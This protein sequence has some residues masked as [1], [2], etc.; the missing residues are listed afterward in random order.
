M[1]RGA[2]GQHVR[3]EDALWPPPA[4]LSQTTK[5]PLARYLVVPNQEH[6]RFFLPAARDA[7]IAVLR[8]FRSDGTPAARRRIAA[9]RVAIRLTGGWPLASRTAVSAPPSN[10]ETIES[11]VASLLGPDLRMGIHF[12]P[13]RANR[14]PILQILDADNQPRAFGKLGVDTLTRTL[15]R[16]EA[17]VLRYLAELDL[18]GIRLPELIHADDWGETTLLLTTALPLARADRSLD[19]AMRRQA[20]VT[21]SRAAGTYAS[22]P[23]S[24]SWLASR[25]KRASALDHAQIRQHLLAALDRLGATEERWE[26]GCWHGDWTVWNAAGL[27]GGVLIWDWER[28]D[29]DVPVGWDALHDWLRDAFVTR[30]PRPDVAKELLDL[31]PSLLEVFGVPQEHAAGVARSYLVELALRY[32]EDRQREAGGRTAR[33]EEWLLP[34]LPIH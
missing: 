6:P 9:L 16:R 1:N 27:D 28:F 26:F 29:R 7:A 30:A 5:D 10:V 11:C 8:H 25:Q 3:L 13:A 17:E 12:G 24:S 31:A 20:M 23:G 18:P 22:L 19:P 2:Q 21:L 15:V 34:V 4:Q 32:T 33:V 14:K